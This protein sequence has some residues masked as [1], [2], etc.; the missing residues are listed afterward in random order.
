MN[1]DLLSRVISSDVNTHNELI[2]RI[3]RLEKRQETYDELRNMSN[4][5]KRRNDSDALHAVLRG[6]DSKKEY[7]RAIVHKNFMKSL[8]R[9][10]ME[11]EYPYKNY[12]KS[13]REKYASK[14]TRDFLSQGVYMQQ[15]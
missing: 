4:R 11:K 1:K 7:A 14:Q 13:K 2:R 3:E 10:R 15:L 5:L 12:E 9:V 6:K 8:N